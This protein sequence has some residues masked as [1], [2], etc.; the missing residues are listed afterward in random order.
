MPLPDTKDGTRPDGADSRSLHELFEEVRT[1]NARMINAH[2]AA[3]GFGDV[4]RDGLLALGLI[5]M[6]ETTAVDI[7]KP[8]GITREAAAGLIDALVKQGYL[9]FQEALPDGGRP[10]TVITGRG[11]AA[12]SAGQA[13]AM[14]ARW[15]DFPFRDDDIVIS[16]APKCGTT[17]VQMICGLL[18]FQTR[19]L[20]AP[21]VDLSPF[22]DWGGQRRAQ[23]HAQLAA[24]EHRRFI[25][26]HQP[27][28]AVPDDPRVTF[29]VM[30]RHPLDAALSLY[31]HLRLVGQASNARRPHLQEDPHEWLVRE[32]NALHAA[33]RPPDNSLARA[34]RV[35]GDAWPRRGEP[36]VVLLHY[37]S[38][39][40][41]MPGEMRRLATRLGIAVP[42]STW[43]GLVSAATFEQMRAAADRIRPLRELDGLPDGQAAF[44]RQGTSGGG[45]ALL[46]TAELARYHAIAARLAPPDLLKWLHRDNEP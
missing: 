13:G 46:T 35:P 23:I 14:P 6:N 19:D 3:T 5:A 25:K 20:P 24:Q 30:A 42:E 43:P 32:I 2:L 44:F 21:L 4:T 9:R 31:Y 37:A 22:M 15:T 16:S 10:A 36:N 17:W 26:T 1:A 8:L 12:I 28:S 27:L 40:A 18:I 34:L 29:I 33:G 11:I 7:A 45:R 39:S 38:L 41:D